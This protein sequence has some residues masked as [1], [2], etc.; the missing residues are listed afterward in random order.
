MSGRLSLT[1]EYENLEIIRVHERNPFKSETAIEMG[2]GK[3]ISQMGAK[4]ISNL[5]AALY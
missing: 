4:T 3:V 5:P 2:I 1:S